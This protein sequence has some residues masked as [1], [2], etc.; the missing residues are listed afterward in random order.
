LSGPAP[1]ELA[2]HA[3]VEKGYRVL[4]PPSERALGVVQ[5]GDLVRVTIRRVQPEGQEGGRP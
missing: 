2:F 4:I 5:P 3:K 1:G